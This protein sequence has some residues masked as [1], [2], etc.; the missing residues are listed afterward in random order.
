M[1]FVYHKDQ[2]YLTT[3]AVVFSI[4]DKQ[5]KILLIQ[6]KYEP[7][8]GK[9]AIPGGFVNIEENLE[10]GV[11]RELEEETGVSGI[12][13]KQ[14]PAFGDVGRDPRGR[15]ITIPFL[16]LIDGEKV[17]VHASGDAELAKWHPA[18]DLPPLA[19]DHKKIFDA[20]LSTLRN[21]IETTNIAVKIMPDKFTL[22]ELQNAYEIILGK[23]LDKRNFRKKIKEL[24]ILK[25]LTETKMEGAHRPAQ[26]HSFRTK[27]YKS[28]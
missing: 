2:F 3:D 26:L 13:L 23:Q 5:L 25:E 1:R 22:S 21:E 7:F 8:K 16:A 6:R 18:Y 4:L 27:A 20:A 11:A 19:F 15:I 9:F 24:D 10:E 28:I 14:M 17:K 12:Y